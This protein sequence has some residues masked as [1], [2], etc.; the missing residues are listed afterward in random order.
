MKSFNQIIFGFILIAVSLFSC[1]KEDTC[2]LTCAA[3]EVLSIDCN[4]VKINNSNVITVASNIT[5][6]TTWTKSKEYHLA[7]RVVVTSGATLTIEAGTVIKG[8]AGSGAN[9]TALIIARGGKIMANGTAAEPIIF[10]TVADQITTGQIESPNMDATQNGLWG[11]VLIL[12]KAPISAS[13]NAESVQIE[14]IPASDINGLY[15]GSDPADNSGVFTYVSIRHGGANI[16]EGNE[17]NGLTLGGVGSGTKI[18]NVEIVSN[19]DDGIEIFGGTVNVNN[20]II[21]NASDDQID[22]D[23]A[24]AGTLDNFIAILGSGSDH[25][26][27]LDGG[28]G[29]ANATFTLSHGTLKGKG[30]NVSTDGE[31]ADLR[32]KVQCNLNSIYFFNFSPNSDLEL[33]NEGVSDNWA[34]GKIVFS[35]L[36]FNV[37][38]L[39]SG[40]N[41]LEAIFKDDGGRDAEFNTACQSFAKIVTTHTQGADVS[42]FKN[43]TVTD[44][45]GI[46]ADF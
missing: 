7:A 15:G 31:Y 11:G 17:I 1:A 23:Q 8:E 35:N 16:G 4:C 24:Y 39:T 22:C 26:L 25:G 19:Q 9:A 5:S 6:N 46:L 37:S 28:E 20:I 42:K 32:D 13:G 41:T 14:G 27:E 30:A 44:K 3:D 10:T 18:E 21:W 33:D 12:G 45:K 2:T 43:W 36:E 29:T 38:Q 34:N 40:N